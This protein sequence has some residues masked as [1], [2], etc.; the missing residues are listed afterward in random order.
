MLLWE[1]NWCSMSWG[2][3]VWS[4]NHPP[5]SLWEKLSSTKPVPGAWKVGDWWSI[6]WFSIIQSRLTMTRNLESQ[7]LFCFQQFFLFGNDE[8]HIFK[9]AYFWEVRTVLFKV[10]SWELFTQTLMGQALRWEQGFP[11]SQEFIPGN[12]KWHSGR[13]TSLWN[14]VGC[15]YRNEF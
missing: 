10:C 7:L 4:R 6:G 9:K 14:R 1:S 2:R 3:T 13:T 8:K 15:T 5:H 11:C 12:S